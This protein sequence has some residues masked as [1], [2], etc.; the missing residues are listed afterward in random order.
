[1]DDLGFKNM[2]VYW[3][4]QCRKPQ[5]HKCAV[6]GIFAAKLKTDQS[7]V[8]ESLVIYRSERKHE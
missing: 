8:I 3:Q 2:K 6:C 7:I 4:L 5:I 1:M